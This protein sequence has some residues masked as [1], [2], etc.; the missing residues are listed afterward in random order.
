MKHNSSVIVS[1]RCYASKASLAMD[2]LHYLFIITT[3]YMVGHTDNTFAILS[4]MDIVTLY[5]NFMAD[6]FSKT[7]AGYSFSAMVSS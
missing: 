2:L 4:L 7:L 1:S 6:R 3:L 5:F